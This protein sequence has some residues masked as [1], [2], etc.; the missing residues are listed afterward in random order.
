MAYACCCASSSCTATAPE[1]ESAL[2]LALAPALTFKDKRVLEV[3]AGAA[4]LAGL[5]VAIHHNPSRIVLSDGNPD[6]VESLNRN[7]ALNQ[8]LLPSDLDISARQL[9]WGLSRTTDHCNQDQLDR[10]DVI[11]VADCTFQVD[12]HAQLLQTLESCLD[13]ESSDARVYM[14]APRRGGSLN[15]FLDLIDSCNCFILIVGFNI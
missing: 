2:A 10:F 8:H 11:L 15:A 14:V 6:S 9:L 3:G 7:I 4:G 5:S 12:T 1:P 13:K